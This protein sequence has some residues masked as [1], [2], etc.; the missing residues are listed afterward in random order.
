MRAAVVTAL[1]AIAF[2]LTLG[3]ES[4]PGSDERT[5]VG[6][7]VC[8]TCHEDAAGA[9]SD[10]HG[11]DAFRQTMHQN[12]LRRPTP[13]SV[14]IDK[15]FRGDSVLK[16]YLAQVQIAGKD[17]LLI[18]LSMSPD[19][20]DYLMRMQ[21]SG[22]G[23]STETMKVSYTQGGNGWKQRYLV[24]VDGAN[25]VGPFQYVMPGY[26]RR[27]ADHG[28]FYFL[29][30]LRWIRIDPQTGEAVLVDPRSNEFRSKSW[31]RMCA[32]C[33]TTGTTTRTV[34][35]GNDTSYFAIWPGK[36]SGVAEYSDA[37][38]K[39]GCENCHGPGSEHVANPTT[40]ENI[41]NPAKWAN[42]REAT[43]LKIDV[44]SQC[45]ARTRSTALTHQFPFDEMRQMR[46]VPGQPLKNFI[47]DWFG[48]MAT[49]ADRSTSYAHQQSGQDYH[50]SKHYEQHVFKNGCWD[51]HTVHYNV[52]GLPS[53]LDRNWYS[54]KAGEGCVACH[55]EKAEATSIDG[56]L[57]NKH[58]HHRQSMSQCV[59]C[60]MTRTGSVGFLDLPGNQY[61]EFTKRLY[62]FSSHTFEVI[63]PEKTLR[64]A[65]AG[66]NLGMMNSCAEGCHRNGRGSRNSNDS[67]PE[68]PSWGIYDN[69]YGLWNQKTDLDLADTLL[70]YYSQWWKTSGVP[71]G[72]SA[73]DER[74]SIVA[75][76]PTPV[77]TS[78]RI[79]CKVLPGE[80]A[81][82]E[83][84]DARGRDVYSEQIDESGAVSRQW[85]AVDR[86]G[87]PLPN[88]SYFVRLKSSRGISEKR[89][90]IE[91]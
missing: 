84:Y 56:V 78:A 35:S 88:G 40:G 46:Y 51:C 79:D 38:T 18:Y 62:D 27:D 3:L 16:A 60:H 21:I 39:I 6:S 37:N 23:P 52:D 64:F 9:S 26:R 63:S 24:D 45:H 87:R 7:H 66:I 11:M 81:V 13:E 22:G 85:S 4:T 44:C 67:I 14:I 83:I 31:D 29:D 36:E 68:A 54:M 70:R 75:I 49:W 30:V 58:T 73:G 10:Y 1:A 89:I 42:T 25:Y 48:D 19:K 34:V 43:D 55:E 2:A 71:V 57:M 82:L 61:W 76:V 90:A 41:I 32:T 59:N 8:A 28:E 80:R 69:V 77:V 5:Y 53:M 65:H 47:N 17:T 86:D 12:M 91:R 33:H 50:R 15:Y 72:A 20:K 74:S